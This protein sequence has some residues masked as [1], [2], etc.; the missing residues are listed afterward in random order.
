MDV[1]S[2]VDDFIRDQP[3]RAVV[4]QSLRGDPVRVQRDASRAFPAASLMKVP[5]VITVLEQLDA[6]QVVPRSDLSATTYP[7]LLEVFDDHHT[8]TLQELCC[9]ML[10]TSDNPIG[11]YLTDRV[12]MTAVTQTARR[13]GTVDTCMR[14]GF[15]DDELGAPARES[16]TT[17]ADMALILQ[18]VASQPHLQPMVRAMRNSMRNF[19]LPLRLPDELPVA[20][21][22]GS[23][24]GLA[25]DAGI[26]FGRDRDVVAVFLTDHQPDTA[27]VGI[28]IGDCIADVW[29][30]L[31]EAV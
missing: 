17:A 23:L 12:G 8:F 10:S 13:I 31:G 11:S 6:K 21:K 22:T 25:H 4:L 14:V 27:L 19:R 26:L 28:Q 5:L 29:Q 16:T 18:Y 3:S 2:L 15:T 30:L 24:R 7:S 1:E 20:H 9:L